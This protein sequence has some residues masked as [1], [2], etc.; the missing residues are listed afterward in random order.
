MRNEYEVSQIR[1][2]SSNHLTVVISNYMFYK[3]CII[4][5]IYWSKVPC[6]LYENT[7]DHGHAISGG[8]HASIC[9]HFI[10]I[11]QAMSN[12][13][14]SSYLK[15]KFKTGYQFL[16]MCG[17]KIRL[18]S[19]RLMCSRYAAFNTPM[20]SSV[21]HGLQSWQS[22]D[23]QLLWQSS[24]AHVAGNT[25]RFFSVTC[26]VSSSTDL[27]RNTEISL[28]HQLFQV[29]MIIWDFRFSQ[30]QVWRWESSGI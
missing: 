14:P 3:I 7:T 20:V 2:R 15:Y 26:I 24:L 1:S 22:G 4:L 10:H 11:V 30:H 6:N 13:L 28:S 19:C 25:T 8:T 16:T 12:N 18:Q 23:I 9:I 27:I 21:R 5:I 17:G 29:Q